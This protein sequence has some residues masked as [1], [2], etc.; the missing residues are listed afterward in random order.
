MTLGFGYP[1]TLHTK[2]A[3]SPSPT[4]TG[5]GFVTKQGLNLKKK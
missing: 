3:L 2:R 5:S 1:V 4:V